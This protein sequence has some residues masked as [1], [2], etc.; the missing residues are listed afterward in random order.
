MKRLGMLLFALLLMLPM[1][2]QAQDSPLP[3]P[4]AVEYQ[5][6]LYVMTSVPKSADDLPAALTFISDHVSDYYGASWSPDGTKLAFGNNSIWDGKQTFQV[7]AGLSYLPGSWT[8]DGQLLFAHFEQ[9]SEVIDYLGQI[10]S[11][12]PTADAQPQLIVNKLPIKLGCGL[13]AELPME[14]RLLHEVGLGN[15]RPLWALTPYGLIYPAN[16]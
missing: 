6:K 11:A 7:A 3:F 16:C 4:L 1:V 14:N 2:I 10:Y 12:A 5:N 15:T 13:G 9:Q 8:A